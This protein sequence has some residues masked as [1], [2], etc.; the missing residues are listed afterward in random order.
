MGAAKA[1]SETGLHPMRQ[2]TLFDGISTIVSLM[3]GSGIFSTAGDIQRGVGSP[4]LSLVLWTITGILALTGALW[5]YIS[6]RLVSYHL[7]P[8]LVMPS[9]AP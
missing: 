9:W 1:A 5:Y 8:L 2:L 4:G 3:V 7:S 6:I